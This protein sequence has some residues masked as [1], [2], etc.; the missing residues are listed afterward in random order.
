MGNTLSTSAQD[1]Q[2]IAHQPTRNLQLALERERE[3]ACNLRAEIA[4]VK[5]EIKQERK[6]RQE[7]ERELWPGYLA[8]C[9]AF[10]YKKMFVPPCVP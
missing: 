10:M 3:A 7:S 2:E 1:I 5:A 9:V 8:R 6:A 4:R